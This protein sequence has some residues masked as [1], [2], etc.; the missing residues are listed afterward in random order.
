MCFPL[1]RAYTW[2]WGNAL[3][4]WDSRKLEFVV[5]LRH[6]VYPGLAHI[7]CIADIDREA[8]IDN[9]IRWFHLSMKVDI[10]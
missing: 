1:G 8:N 6:S 5:L 10:A 2:V 3:P 7:D 9:Q 4:G